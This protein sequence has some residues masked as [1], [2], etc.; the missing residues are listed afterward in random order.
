M[1]TLDRSLRPFVGMIEFFDRVEIIFRCQKFPPFDS[2]GLR[3]GKGLLSDLSIERE[4]FVQ[5]IR[6][7][8][9]P[10]TDFATTRC[11]FWLVTFYSLLDLWVH[12]AINSTDALHEADR[13]P[14]NVI[15]HHQ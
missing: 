2:E 4:K 11:N 5:I 15:V 9:I 10:E 8:K 14:M 3:N 1:H 13:I 12:A 7:E 6:R